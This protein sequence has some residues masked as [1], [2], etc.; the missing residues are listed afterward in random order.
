MRKEG[1]MTKDCHSCGHW[2]F[3]LVKWGINCKRQ[4]G[5]RIPR[6]KSS[7]IQARLSSIQPKTKQK[8]NSMFKGFEPI[9]TKLAHW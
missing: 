1:G 3:C 4:G 7:I 8:G 5:K 6:M 9:R 2:G